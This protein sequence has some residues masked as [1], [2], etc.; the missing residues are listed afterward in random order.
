MKTQGVITKYLL[1]AT[2]LFL[3]AAYNV[4]DAADWANWR[5]PDYNGI[6][7]EKD[8]DPMKIKEGVEPLWRASIGTGFSTISVSNGRVYAMGNTGVKGEDEVNYR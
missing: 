1:V 8:W 3:A 6:S 5:G 2:F 4:V 7:A